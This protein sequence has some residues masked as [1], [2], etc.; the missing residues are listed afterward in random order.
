MPLVS[1]IIPIY[2]VPEK[3]LRKSIESVIGQTLKDIEIILVDDGSPDNCGAICDAYAENDSRVKVIHQQ[4]KGLA[5]ARNSGCHAAT[6]KYI[7]F[8]D[9]DDWLE[10]DTFEIS[11]NAAES[12]NVQI[13]IWK[14]VRDFEKRIEPFKYGDR[15]LYDKVYTGEECAYLQEMVLHFEGQISQ[16]FA[17]LILREYIEKNNIYHGE[18]LR[19]GAEDIEF[20]VRLF[21]NATRIIFIDKYFL[22]YTYN[23]NSISSFVS[24]YNNDC[25]IRCFESIKNFVAHSKNSKRLS[26]WVDNRL[27]YV[28][29]TAGISG[30]FHPKNTDPYKIQKKKYKEFLK[31]PIIA[32]ALKTKNKKELSKQRK[33]VLWLIK[34][35][36]FFAIKILAKM[37]YRQKKRNF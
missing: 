8:L 11:L 17:K 23:P 1:I 18:E 4:N 33:I 9:G 34:H 25:I 29:I 12:N 7:S 14:I 31:Q 20:T 35:K 21:E 36:M 32:E 3:Y 13:V 6:G 22:H 19:Q 26:P 5:G 27:L 15:Y 28:A 24:Q 2:K 16:P 37:R 30:Y 10:N